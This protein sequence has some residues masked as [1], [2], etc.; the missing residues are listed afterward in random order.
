[1]ISK[2]SITGTALLNGVKPVA[3]GASAELFPK[4]LLDSR[5]EVGEAAR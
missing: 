4:D 2:P 3:P 1:M 5:C